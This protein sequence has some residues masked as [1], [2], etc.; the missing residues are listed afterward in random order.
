M[1]ARLASLILAASILATGVA[2]SASLVDPSRLPGGVRSVASVEGIHE[3]ALPNGLRVILFPD[4]SKQT[5]TVCVTYIVGSRHEAYGETGMAHLL[6]HLMFK[7]SAN[8][9]DIPGE[10]TAHGCRPNGSTWFDRTNYFETFAATE[11]NLSWALEM[12]ADRMVNSFIAQKDLDSEMTVVRNEFESGENDPTAVLEERVFSTAYLWHNY[13]NSTIGCRADIENVPI[14]RLQ[15]FYR[16]WYQPD[17]AVLVIAGKFDAEKTL[18]LVQSSFGKIP[19]P[20][21]SI[22]RTYTAEPPQDGERTVTLRRV[23]DTQAVAVAYHVPAGS[24]PDF[25]AIEV[26]ASILNEE[27]SGRLYKDLVE[28][29]K[30]V[31]VRATAYQLAEPGMLVASAEVRSDRPLEEARRSML[32][33]VEGVA[34]GGVTAAELA[35]AQEGLLKDWE[36]AMLNSQRAAIGLSEWAAMGD[37]RLLF[38]HRDR[39][40]AVTA[41][42]VQRVARTYL[43][44][45]NRTVGTFIPTEAPERAEVPPT[46]DVAAMVKDYRGGEEIVQGEEFDTSP[47]AIERQVIRRTLP[48]GLRLVMLPKKTRGGAV[49]ANLNLRFGD[50]SSLRGTARVAELTGSMLMRGTLKRT[51]QE[52]Q[53]ETD[54]LR[55][56]LFAG[57][58]AGYAFAN[59]QT[60][61]ENLAEAMGLAVEILREPAFPDSEFDTMK[62]ERLLRLEEAKTDPGA[63]AFTALQRHLRPY[64]KDDVRYTPTPEESIVEVEA[65]T[66]QEAREFHGSFYGASDGS[67][68]IV[69]DFDPGDVEPLAARILGDWKSPRPYARIQDPFE[70]RPV[71]DE[72][73]ETP[74]K[75]SAVMAA[76]LRM[77]L[78][79]DDP[80]YPALALANFMTG[81]G[82]LNSR[83][84]TRIRQKDG[85]SYGVGS[86][87]FASAFDRNAGFVTRAIC[88]PQNAERLVAAFKEEIDRIVRA[89]FTDEEI[90][91]AKSGYLQQRVVSRSQDREVAETLA[92]R[93]EE[94]RDLLWDAGVEERIRNLTGEE[95]HAA[96]KRHIDAGKISIV[97]AGDFARVG[98]AEMETE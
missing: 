53:D 72:R 75:E 37:W 43:V 24:H 36:M 41:E 63:K 96:F 78:R 40:R 7:G 31:D 28:T 79:D 87:L 6:E 20:Q 46:T 95:I 21:R 8:H 81:G 83:L 97:L 90:A 80:D 54:R 74:D 70:A 93:E 14:E 86:M 25:A 49:Q 57:G 23:G 5:T 82:F 9:P 62:Q 69:G 2:A 85:L 60:T 42:D 11:E 67:L 12:E 16:K 76:G 19:R 51:R 48:S 64:P 52:I 32:D 73:I 27:P 61:R 34:E 55:A 77:E 29:K 89:G 94:E 88:A 44:E 3:Y 4:P 68:V 26:L 50:E 1:R 66:L 38:L 56:R 59:L 71:I 92:G 39:L 91:E 22:E 17:N 15:A 30:A 98:K 13:G 35:R 65:V 47:E 33:A 58:G 18:G 10:L 84:A 45:N